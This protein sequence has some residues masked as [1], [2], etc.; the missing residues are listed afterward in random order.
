MVKIVIILIII[1]MICCAIK[2]FAEWL[3]ENYLYFLYYV[4][5]IAGCILTVKKSAW[6]ILLPISVVVL[7]GLRW[8]FVELR[9]KSEIKRR[10]KDRRNRIANNYQW[11][12]SNCEAFDVDEIKEVLQIYI[13]GI[14]DK[15]IDND[16]KFKGENIPLGRAN[17]F[18][19]AFERNINME[20]PLYFSCKNSRVNTELKEYGMLITTYGIYFVQQVQSYKGNDYYSST[21]KLPFSG[22][23]KVSVNKQDNN[24]HRLFWEGINVDGDN[25]S[26][27]IE[28]HKDI[29]EIIKE[30]CNKVISLKISGMMYVQNYDTSVVK[31]I[32]NDYEWIKYINSVASTKTASYQFEKIYGETKNYMNGSA[33]NGY[34]AE[35]GNNTIDRMLGKE[36]ESTA[37]VLDSNGRQVKGGADRTVENVEI[38][39]KYYKTAYDSVNAAFKDGKPIYIRT[40]G[41]GKMMV[42]EV[43]RDQY[44]KA[45]EIMQKKIDDGMIPGVEK[46]ENAS[47]YV[48]KGLYTYEQSWNIAKAGTIEGITV[49][50]A[51]GI[52]YAKGV[53]CMSSVLVF[54]QLVWSGNSF[55]D[56]IEASVYEGA[57]V[58][59]KSAM[60]NVLTMQLSRKEIANLFV[61][62]RLSKGEIKGYAGVNNPFYYL[63]ENIAYKIRTST[64]A[65][66]TFGNKFALKNMTG[67]RVISN[68]IVGV[69]TYGPD[70]L[71][72]IEG[73]IS[74]KQFVKNSAIGTAGLVGASI[75]NGLFPIAGGVIGGTIGGF[76]AKRFL[77]QFIED[78][79]IEMFQIFKEELIEMIGMGNLDNNEIEELLNMTVGNKELHKCLQNMYMSERY[80]EY[81]KEAIMKPAYER[82]ISRRKKVKV[83]DYNSSLTNM[84]M[85]KDFDK[86]QIEAR[87]TKEL[88]SI[89]ASKRHDICEKMKALIR[90][91]FSSVVVKEKVKKT[92]YSYKEILAKSTRKNKY[93]NLFNIMLT[94]TGCVALGVVSRQLGIWLLKKDFWLWFFAGAL[95]FAGAI[96][97]IGV[98]FKYVLE[99]IGN[100]HYSK[101]KYKEIKREYS[102]YIKNEKRN[103]A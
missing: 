33:G 49:D 40:D 97:L 78:D 63:S 51:N 10:K 12:K 96:H 81:A 39:T 103:I 89:C 48:K 27:N 35:Y 23:K 7:L 17:V 32:I 3:K 73:K 91:K 88:E 60:I 85:E 93:S 11:L 6:F 38:Q 24:Y 58:L 25:I 47:D 59:G 13:D 94:L 4:G 18:L 68:S 70:V 61:K 21:R 64:I 79:S 62:E 54:A 92:L 65:N 31:Y 14:F 29:I 28:I 50:V 74:S 84:I 101:K 5:M 53:A 43:P 36:V 41:T 2:A 46:G 9:D 90:C 99:C 83:E 55:E 45:L 42:I 86:Q 34:A 44:K 98:M 76:V 30:M 22:L 16:H 66:S 8:M 69:M 67:K 57:K 19:N 52:I 75:G 72:I 80:R 100:I 1:G 82:I 77:D 95:T 87:E 26:G 71:K 20:E 15:D 102:V 37:Q 56:A